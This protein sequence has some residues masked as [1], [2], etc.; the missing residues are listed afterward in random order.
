MSDPL[1]QVLAAEAD[2][3]RR[4]DEAHQELEDELRAARLD[5]RRIKERNEQRTRRAVAAAEE[6][7]AA[8]TE[9]AIDALNEAFSRELTLDDESLE[10]RLEE[11]TRRHVDRLWPD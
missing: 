5:A 2:A 11:L 6:K 9:Q 7:C 1:Q 10:Q 3:R 4:I 8:Q